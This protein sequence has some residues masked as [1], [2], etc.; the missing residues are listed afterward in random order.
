MSLSI[1]LIGYIIAISHSFIH[2][3]GRCELEFE[4]ACVAVLKAR[5]VVRS[6]GGPDR[7]NSETTFM[8]I[9]YK[10]EWLSRNRSSDESWISSPGP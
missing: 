5:E 3:A 7:Q 8:S 6:F 10:I 2:H 9:R 1:L 4:F